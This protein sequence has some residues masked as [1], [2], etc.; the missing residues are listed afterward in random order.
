[1][2][3]HSFWRELSGWDIAP[4]ARFTAALACSPPIGRERD[5][6]Q[7]LGSRRICARCKIKDLHATTAL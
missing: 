6:K 3:P 5:V 4:D 2:E 7:S 1:M